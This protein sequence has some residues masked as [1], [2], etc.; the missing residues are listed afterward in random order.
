M[1]RSLDQESETPVTFEPVTEIWQVTAREAIRDL[2]TRYNA[3]GDTGRFAQVRE[4]FLPDAVMTIQG[5]AHRGI[6]RIMDIFTGSTQAT[7]GLTRSSLRG[8]PPDRSCR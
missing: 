6:D 3:N 2:V 7:P 1:S 8:H 4:L 5:E